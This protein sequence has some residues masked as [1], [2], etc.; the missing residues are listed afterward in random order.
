M[1]A[2]YYDYIIADDIVIPDENKQYF[3]EHVVSLPN[4]YWVNS[5]RQSAVDMGTTESVRVNNT[6]NELARTELG[7]PKDKIIM[8]Y[9][10][11]EG[12]L[13]P[14]TYS[15]WMRILAKTAN[16]VLWLISSSSDTSANIYAEVH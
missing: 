4:S 8:C 9:F 10:G 5:H 16:T 2:D 11:S 7:L 6:K 13:D 12:K 15:I 3:Q 14:E 1:G